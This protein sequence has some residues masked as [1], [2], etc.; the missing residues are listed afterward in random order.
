VYYWGL[1]TKVPLC[2]FL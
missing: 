2:I 1:H